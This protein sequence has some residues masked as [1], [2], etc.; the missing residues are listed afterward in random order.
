MYCTVCSANDINNILKVI[1]LLFCLLLLAYCS[2]R[3]KNV[4]PASL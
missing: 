3:E 2:V 4:L 1:K